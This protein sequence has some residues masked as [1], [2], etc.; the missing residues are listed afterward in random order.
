MNG[1][2]VEWVIKSL[3][4][5]LVDGLQLRQ[6]HFCGDE[7][8]EQTGRRRVKNSIGI[9]CLPSPCFLEVIAHLIRP[10]LSE[11]DSELVKRI[12]APDES[13]N[14]RSMLVQRKNLTDFIRSQAR[15]QHHVR[16]TIARHHTMGNHRVGHALAFQLFGG[17][18][19]RESICNTTVV[20]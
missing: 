7:S 5:S 18:A 2:T 10:F 16:R 14:R 4:W 6:I 17:L 11:L 9:D 20:V 8:L 3:K 19:A 1:D 12:D 15:Q 13:F